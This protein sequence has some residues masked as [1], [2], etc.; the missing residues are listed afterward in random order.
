MT[1]MG[2]ALFVTLAYP[3]ALHK[4]E[5][6]ILVVNIMRIMHKTDDFDSVAFYADIAVHHAT[7]LFMGTYEMRRKTR[8][9][10]L[11]LWSAIDPKRRFDKQSKTDLQRIEAGCPG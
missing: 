9:R 8:D 4:L 7:G 6:G 1:G 11:I 5:T 3:P 10:T 2:P